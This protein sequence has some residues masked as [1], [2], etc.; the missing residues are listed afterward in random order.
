MGY[1]PVDGGRK[2]I[3]DNIRELLE[4]D[5][6]RCNNCNRKL[7]SKKVIGRQFKIMYCPICD[8]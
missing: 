7:E 5:K 2:R 3:E 8:K 4:I 1:V 6:D